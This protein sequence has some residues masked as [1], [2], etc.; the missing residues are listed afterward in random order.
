M[1][2]LGK[3]G[4]F[5]NQILQYIFLRVAALQSGAQTQCPP[6]AGHALFGLN[7]P[8]VTA[9][10][11]PAIEHSDQSKNLFDLIPELIPYIENLTRQKSCRVNHDAL[12]TGLANLDLWG[13][14]QVHSRLLAPHKEFIRSLF[15]PVPILLNQLHTAHQA[16][17]QQG[18]TL[19]GLHIRRGDFLDLPLFGFT[20]PVP[21]HWWRDWLDRIWPSLHHPV[22]LVCSDALDEVLPHFARFSP[23]TTQ[24]FQLPDSDQFRDLDFFKDFYLLTQCDILNISNST[25]SF[26]AALLNKT[27]RQFFRPNWNFA[28]RFSPF[29]PW[30]SDPLLYYGGAQPKIFKS[31]A[32]ALYVARMTGGLPALL[33]CGYIYPRERL[34]MRVNRTRYAYKI[35]GIHAAMKSLAQPLAI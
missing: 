5:G 23:V 12:Q 18:S 10:L 14:F 9:Q 13:F 33:Q 34:K 16:I 4:R 1:S 6:W 7:D 27:A 15:Q 3:L 2:S 28:T 30:D 32:D 25:F 17:R 26:S 24:D 8:P 21:V 11:P 19:V 35:G 20:Y 31:F 22:L 29:D